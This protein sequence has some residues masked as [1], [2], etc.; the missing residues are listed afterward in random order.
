MGS[1]KD[2]YEKCKVLNS[3]LTHRILLVILLWIKQCY[4]ADFTENDY[5]LHNALVEW[6]Q[7]LVAYHRSDPDHE[8]APL[9]ALI[10]RIENELESEKVIDQLQL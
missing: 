7:K 9:L 2:S 10:Q 5:E 6:T 3:V 8:K 1:T 4:G